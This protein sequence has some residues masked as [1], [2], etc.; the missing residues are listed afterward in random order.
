MLPEVGLGKEGTGACANALC[1]GERVFENNSGPPI[2]QDQSCKYTSPST[3]WAAKALEGIIMKG[4]M[5]KKTCLAP[6]HNKVTRV[7]AKQTNSS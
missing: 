7:T 6:L 1:G 4:V 3:A 5:R 2:K